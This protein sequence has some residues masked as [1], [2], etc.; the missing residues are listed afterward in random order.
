MVQA[1]RDDA[2][3]S[4]ERQNYHLKQARWTSLLLYIQLSNLL[5]D[6][7]CSFACL[8]FQTLLSYMMGSFSLSFVM[9]V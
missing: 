6:H 1:K 8:T 2:S 3:C 7:F 9:N 4:S 5:F